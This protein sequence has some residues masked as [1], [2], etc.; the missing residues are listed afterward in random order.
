MSS[1]S[2]KTGAGEDY[3]RTQSD[4]QLEIC[5]LDGNCCKTG[6]LEKAGLGLGG[7]ATYT[8][9]TALNTCATVSFTKECLKI[10]R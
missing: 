10:E 8:E 9:P 3:V 2:I 4:A 6:T 5:D 7:I 1:I